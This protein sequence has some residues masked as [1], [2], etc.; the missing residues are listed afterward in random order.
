MR[1]ALLADLLAILAAS[2]LIFAGTADAARHIYWA[3]NGGNTIGRANLEGSNPNESFIKVMRGVGFCGVAVDGSHVYSSGAWIGRARLDGSHFRFIVPTHVQ[4]CGVAVDRSHLYWGDVEVCGPPVGC[5]P[6]STLSRATLNGGDFKGSFIT[7]AR[8]PCGVAADGS[9]VYWANEAGTTISR[10][11]LNGTGRDVSFITGAP[12]PCGVAVDGSHVY[13]AN[14]QGNTIGRAKLDG[15]SV[16]QSF[17]TGANRPS[18]VAVDGAH[19]YWSNLFGNTIG[20][21]NLNGTGTNQSFI[22]GANRPWGVAVDPRRIS[23][24][25]TLTYSRDAHGFKGVLSSTASACERDQIVT[26]YRK[27][28]GADHEVGRARTTVAGAYTLSKLRDRGSYYATVG[29]TTAFTPSAVACR[30]ATSPI[31]RLR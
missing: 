3:N 12:V 20:R 13:W 7:G 28:R 18:G 1:R 6:G 15:S 4:A 22:T 8:G 5:F 25:L 31:V 16:D 21:A 2:F 17:I 29:T 19:V 9:Y 30:S 11:K 27:R 26:V 14:Q 24:S 23:R 10:A